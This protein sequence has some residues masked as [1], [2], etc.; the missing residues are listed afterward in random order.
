MLMTETVARYFGIIT[1]EPK[2]NFKLKIGV[3]FPIIFVM[4]V[5]EKLTEFMNM[6]MM[7]YK[8][9]Y[10]CWI[11]RHCHKFLCVLLY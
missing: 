3:F 2:L 10:K 6:P 1:R 8:L 5:I 4:P 11:N 9:Q 7:E